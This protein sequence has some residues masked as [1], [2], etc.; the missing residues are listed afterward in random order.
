M[1]EHIQGKLDWGKES[2][3]QDK[4][5]R[6]AV[7]D[8][9]LSAVRFA[10]GSFGGGMFWKTTQ[11][12]RLSAEAQ[13]SRYSVVHR[14][15]SRRE[16]NTYHVGRRAY[17]LIGEDGQDLNT[18]KFR[19]RSEA[20]AHKD[21]I[22]K[23]ISNAEYIAQLTTDIFLDAYDL[24]K[25][26]VRGELRLENNTEYQ[27]PNNLYVHAQVTETGNILVAF[28][29]RSDAIEKDP[30]GINEKKDVTYLD[31]LMVL[32]FD[33]KKGLMTAIVHMPIDYRHMRGYMTEGTDMSSSKPLQED[34]RPI[35]VNKDII[36][37]IAAH[38]RNHPSYPH[39]TRTSYMS[40]G[41]PSTDL[42]RAVSSALFG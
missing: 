21:E 3:K 37:V 12:M 8:D 29:R 9:I 19:N 25:N 26:G 28:G 38:D 16:R 18:M 11:G 22:Q 40:G 27:L 35:L 6:S 13:Q 5:F 1:G 4:P 7:Y 32:D 30:Q 31:S 24:A 17:S 41:F 14:R 23:A 34:Y 42:A 36:Q 39:D 2:K 33:I 10:A 20:V 15:V